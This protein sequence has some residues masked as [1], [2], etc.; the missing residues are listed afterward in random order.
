MIL[1]LTIAHN[2]SKFSNHLIR[3][4]NLKHTTWNLF[5]KTTNI[6]DELPIGA[7]VFMW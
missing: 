7:G 4:K 1:K 3:Q 6:L 2:C 5:L